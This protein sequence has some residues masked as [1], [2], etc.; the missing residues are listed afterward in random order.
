M[1]D[2]HI[3]ATVSRYNAFEREHLHAAGLA[4]IAQLVQSESFVTR[5]VAPLLAAAA[6]Q[7][8]DLYNQRL[9]LY[10][11]GKQS[12]DITT[13]RHQVVFAESCEYGDIANFI[14]AA[15]F[16]EIVRDAAMMVRRFP[17]IVVPTQVHNDTAS[18]VNM[19][20][21]VTWLPD[22]LLRFEICDS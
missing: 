19:P 10:T 21:K 6:Q 12:R 3:V 16:A 17:N 1:L 5:F 15:D 7:G 20:F 4:E 22:T 9:K 2:E 13:L 8:T 18:N 11:I 14:T